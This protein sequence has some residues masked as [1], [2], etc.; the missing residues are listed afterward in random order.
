MQAQ[1]NVKE[2]AEQKGEVEDEDTKDEGQ[3][4][5]DMDPPLH[6]LLHPYSLV[7]VDN[8]LNAVGLPS[9][10]LELSGGS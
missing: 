4:R 7:D 10:P 3:A 2:E 8:F 1:E 6:D 9:A 5:V